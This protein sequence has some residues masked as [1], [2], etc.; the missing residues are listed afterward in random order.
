MKIK[1]LVKVYE[2]TVING[3]VYGDDDCKIYGD[4]IITDKRILIQYESAIYIIKL[5]EVS[6][7]CYYFYDCGSRCWGIAVYYG[8]KND[9]R[10]YFP[11]T[12]EW[13]SWSEKVFETLNKYIV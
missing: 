12:T 9:E 4:I 8:E 6:S 1:D 10:I 7:I 5:S 11:N 13:R 2:N 3:H